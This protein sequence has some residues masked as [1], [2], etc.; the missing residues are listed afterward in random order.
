M[1][2]PPDEAQTRTWKH[3]QWVA[4]GAATDYRARQVVLLYHQSSVHNQSGAYGAH[5]ALARQWLARC[6]GLR[7]RIF[8]QDAVAVAKYL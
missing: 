7:D 1:A 4:L 3:Q 6:G 2:R 8:L 5:T